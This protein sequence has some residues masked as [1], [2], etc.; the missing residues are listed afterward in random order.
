MKKEEV[1]SL[2]HVQ[3]AH[4]RIGAHHLNL[5]SI[6][7]LSSQLQLVSISES[8]WIWSSHENVKPK[9]HTNRRQIICFILDLLCIQT[10]DKTKYIL[11]YKILG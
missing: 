6:R 11:L 4:V 1:R 9:E 5:N 2:D 8:S 3:A 7:C 10:D